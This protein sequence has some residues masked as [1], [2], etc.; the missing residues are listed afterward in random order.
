MGKAKK[1]AK[2]KGKNKAK[3]K[4]KK[5]TKKKKKAAKKAKKKAKRKAKRKAKAKKA[6]AKAKAKK[7]KRKATKNAL[8]SALKKAGKK[9]KKAKKKK[10][11]VLT[12]DA[13]FD[14]QAHASTLHKRE[15]RAKADVKRT[16][17]KV[18]YALQRMGQD[19][20]SNSNGPKKDVTGMRKA[21]R[22]M[23]FDNYTTAS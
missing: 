1:K 3:K 11:M 21:D 14:A 7:K 6:K 18:S 17:H 12:D 2:K 4:K 5:A 20:V 19:E 9:A 16:W 22:K 8:A 23:E 13:I 15:I 10:A